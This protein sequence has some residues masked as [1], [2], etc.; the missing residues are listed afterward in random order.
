MV[1]PSSHIHRS[2]TLRAS[3][4]NKE[5][6]MGCVV[7]SSGVA[8]STCTLIAGSSDYEADQHYLY[9]G[10]VIECAYVSDQGSALTNTLGQTGQSLQSARWGAARTLDRG[11]VWA[12]TVSS[13]P[14]VHQDE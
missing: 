8:T 2:R 3:A 11:F 14:M 10:S 6:P 12:F 5:T 7:T 9:Y 13:G 1:R 4:V